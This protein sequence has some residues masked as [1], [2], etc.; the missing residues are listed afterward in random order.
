MNCR[1][2]VESVQK[3]GFVNDH[4]Q[5]NLY[6]SIQLDC[7]CC[8]AQFQPWNRNRFQGAGADVIFPIRMNSGYYRQCYP[9][10]KHAVMHLRNGESLQILFL[11]GFRHFVTTILAN[12]WR[13]ECHYSQFF[14]LAS[15]IQSSQPIVF[16]QSPCRIILAVKMNGATNP[17]GS[18]TLLTIDR[19]LR[20]VDGFSF[21]MILNPNS[22]LSTF[23]CIP[24]V[25]S[26]GCC[27][28]SMSTT[29]AALSF[30]GMIAKTS[31]RLDTHFVRRKPPNSNDSYK[32]FSINA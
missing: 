11:A 2:D 18:Y 12:S 13:S 30:L 7:Q 14:I 15:S 26:N 21:F 9:Y 20:L 17:K 25:R 6:H 24:R 28:Q 8:R 5:F 19:I 27:S 4:I 32:T 23:H 29:E 1:T 3:N 31:L 16:L 10:P 22:S